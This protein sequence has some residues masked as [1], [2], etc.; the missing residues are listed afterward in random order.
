MDTNKIPKSPIFLKTCLD[1]LFLFLMLGVIGFTIMAGFYLFSGETIPFRI[2]DIEIT[3][4]N[5]ATAICMALELLGSLLFLFLIWNFRKLVRL[6]F[7]RKLF[8]R[9]QIRKTGL[10]GKLSI[11]IAIIEALIPLIF[12]SFG[13]PQES[14]RVSLRF[15]GEGFGSFLFI[16]AL[17]LFFIY[18]SRIFENARVW[19]E[20]N[21]LTV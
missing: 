6:F 2:N 17:G 19:K 15:G 10:I 9:E 3:Q 4:F 14:L 12:N 18:L 1:I 7:K 20:E 5:T 13:N 11:G 8:T 16:L 21:E